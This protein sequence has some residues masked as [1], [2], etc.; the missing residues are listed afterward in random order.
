MGID[1]SDKWKLFHDEID[2][3]LT[4]HQKPINTG[5]VIG[6]VHI[7]LDHL[8]EVEFDI[9]VLNYFLSDFLK[10]HNGSLVEVRYLSQL[11][12]D[13]IIS[14]MRIGSFVL[15]NDINHYNI[16]DCFDVLT[17]EIKRYKVVKKY[18]FDKP[19]KILERYTPSYNNRGNKI[20]PIPKKYLSQDFQQAY[21]PRTDCSSAQ[22]VIEVR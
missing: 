22:V 14:R 13:K 8:N 12:Y 17:S 7:V 9:L 20:I 21:N 3:L 1:L 4:A 18:R 2:R 19:A 5:F 6:D 16:R 10:I 11:I 15:I